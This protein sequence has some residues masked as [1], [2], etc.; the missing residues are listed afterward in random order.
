MHNK[1]YPLFLAKFYIT[2]KFKEFISACKSAFW[3]TVLED[4]FV[5]ESKAN[6]GLLWNWNPCPTSMDKGSVE[7]NIY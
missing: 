5:V 4:S 1:L 2:C 3:G 6:I 7:K